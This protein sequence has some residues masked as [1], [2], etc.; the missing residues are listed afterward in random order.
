MPRLAM[1]LSEE[2]EGLPFPLL[3]DQD[4]AL[5]EQLGAWGKKMSYGKESIGLIRS[6]FVSVP[7]ASSTVNTGAS[8]PPATSPA[9]PKTSES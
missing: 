7:M 3:S 1:P 4:H 5:A 2:K 8:R 6:T 9:S